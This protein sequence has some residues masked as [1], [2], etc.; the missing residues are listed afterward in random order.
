M[1]RFD[2]TCDNA[3]EFSFLNYHANTIKKPDVTW[4]FDRE[5]LT[6]IAMMYFKLQRDVDDNMKRELP[7]ASFADVLQKTFGM[8]PD[9]VLQHRIF[10]AFELKSTVP[11]KKW[12]SIMSLFLRGTLKEKIEYCFRVYD[13]HD[14]EGIQR[15]QA[16]SLAKKFFYSR[17]I[18][19]NDEIVKDF[20]ELLFDKLDLDRDKIISLEDYRAAIMKRPILL[21]CF[22]QCLPERQ[23]VYAFQMTFTDKIREM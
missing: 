21:E 13:I 2:L 17:H 6:A 18:E 19:D 5:E 12:I 3:E 4:H 15:E 23:I 11:L 14:K 7:I 10:A 8:Y 1:P 20:T 16:I 9:E 22:G